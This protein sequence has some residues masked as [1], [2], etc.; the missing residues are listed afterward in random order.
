[1]QAGLLISV[2]VLLAMPHGPL[3]LAAC[4]DAPGDEAAV[5]AARAAIAAACDCA[6]AP[7]HGA[8]VR[9]AADVA[10]QRLR[11]GTLSRAC[12]ARVRRCASR[13]TCGR[14]GAVVCCHVGAAGARCTITNG[15]ASC[16]APLGGTVC[17]GDAE[18]CCDTCT[19]CPP[20]LPTTTTVPR[21]RSCLD[22]AP[23]A[24]CGSD[25]A[26]PAGYRCLDGECRGGGCSTRGDCAA[27]GECVVEGDADFGRCI[28]QGCEGLR[29][30]RTCRR[31][32]VL[33]G[34]TCRVESDCPPEDDVCFLGRCS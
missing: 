10:R 23:P 19:S 3:A 29:C 9:C 8:Y 7:S 26:C 12:R 6:R 24:S 18:S 17:T 33:T 14:P 27:E 31:G 32:G 34:C 30:P 16:R 28:C 22:L 4:G 25:A 11:E 20:S 1:M 2:I 21:P 5:V 13:S 15:V